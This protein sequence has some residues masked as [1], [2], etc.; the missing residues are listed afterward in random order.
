MTIKFTNNA[1]A[2]LGASISSGDT[3]ITLAAGQGALFPELSVGDYFYGTLVDSSNNLE[4]VQVTARSSD[5]LTVIRGQ[6]GTT[7]RSYLAGDNLE[8]RV[9]AASLNSF[10]AEIEDNADQISDHINDEVGAHAASAISNTPAGS[11]E[12][13]T[14]QAAINELDTEKFAKT[15]GAITGATTFTVSGANNAVVGTTGGA[16]NFGG[17]FS[18]N[19]SGVTVSFKAGGSDAASR[20]FSGTKDETEILYCD[21]DG[22]LVAAGNVTAYSDQRLKSDIQTIDG[23]LELVSRMRGVSFMKDGERGIGVVAQEMQQVLPEVV[24]SKD[25]YLSVA[26]GNIVGVLIEAVKEL[27][28]EVQALKG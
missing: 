9:V 13:T 26:Y 19:D 7:A 2:T 8:L 17:V 4:I 24:Y 21:E 5:N 12:A 25:D 3:T 16:S 6:D 27:Q 10:S 18:N 28:A 22:N 14:V 15:G 20:L 23:A 1:S 11:I